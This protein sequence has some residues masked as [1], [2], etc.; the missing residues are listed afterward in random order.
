MHLICDAFEIKKHQIGS[1]TVDDIEIRISLLEKKLRP[2]M[3]NHKEKF[4]EWLNSLSEQH[5][6]IA[7]SSAAKHLAFNAWLASKNAWL[8][9][10]MVYPDNGED[11]PIMPTVQKKTV[12]EEILNELKTIKN[13]IAKIPTSKYSHHSGGPL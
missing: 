9:I 5:M 3:I 4:D 7:E 13:S 2:G 11:K 12:L 8:G 10:P 6:L 1:N